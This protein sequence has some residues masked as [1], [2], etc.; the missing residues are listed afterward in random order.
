MTHIFVHVSFLRNAKPKVNVHHF[1]SAANYVHRRYAIYSTCQVGGTT[2]TLCTYMYMYM[3]MY[4]LWCIC[5]S[6]NQML[7]IIHLFIN[8]T[9]YVMTSLNHKYN[10]H[11][12]IRSSPFFWFVFAFSG[13]YMKVT[14]HI[15]FE[16]QFSFWVAFDPQ[17]VHTVS[18]AP[19][20]W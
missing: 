5:A 19:S 14:L 4:M 11:W 9:V 18:G 17:T 7:W 1:T 3:Y 2:C 16:S 8:E 13:V 12:N 10:E 20:L 6:I 15:L